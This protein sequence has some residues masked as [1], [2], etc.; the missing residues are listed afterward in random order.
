MPYRPVHR[1]HG[2][3]TKREAAQRQ[4]KSGVTETA[5]RK[6]QTVLKEGVDANPG[7]A[8]KAHARSSLARPT[9]KQ[10]RYRYPRQHRLVPPFQRKTSIAPTD[11]TLHRMLSR[12]LS[13]AV[14]APLPASFDHTTAG[15]CCLGVYRASVQHSPTLDWKNL[16]NG[17]RVLA[18]GERRIMSSSIS[19]PLSIDNELPEEAIAVLLPLIITVSTT[20]PGAPKPPRTGNSGR[21]STR[22]IYHTSSTVYNI[23]ATK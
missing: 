14:T 16:K 20:S 3:E 21:I 8:G 17:P 19:T 12:A 13:L 2:A 9:A 5:G 7:T 6:G 22:Y 23:V 15:R 11:S 10:E 4:L 1:N 18:R